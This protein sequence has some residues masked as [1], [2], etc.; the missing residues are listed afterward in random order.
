MAAKTSLHIP[1]SSGQ[2]F[3]RRAAG[4]QARAG[5][6]PMEEATLLAR[7]VSSCQFEAITTQTVARSRD[8]WRKRCGS[9]V[10]WTRR[11]GR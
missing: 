2:A 4:G 1:S 5:A 10:L 11:V 8:S 7:V 9:A 6:L 3:S